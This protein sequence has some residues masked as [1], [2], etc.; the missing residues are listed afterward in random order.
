M[1]LGLQMISIKDVM[2]MDICASI[3]DVGRVGYEGVEFA[4]G[5]DVYKRQVEGLTK[6]CSVCG[7]EGM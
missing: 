1:R 4:R 5:L 7:F 3:E 2:A 6:G